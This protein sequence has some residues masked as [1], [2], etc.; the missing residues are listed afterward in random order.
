MNE[1]TY[2]TNVASNWTTM[3]RSTSPGPVEYAPD[4]TGVT[5]NEA[6]MEAD[7]PYPYQL[8]GEWLVVVKRAGGEMDFYA[9]RPSIRSR[10]IRFLRAA[11]AP[12]RQRP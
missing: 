2:T 9:F 11:G 5:F 10:F 3:Y 1:A 8:G 4:G 12:A 7:R 6:A